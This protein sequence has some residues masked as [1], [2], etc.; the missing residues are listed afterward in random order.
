MGGIIKSAVKVASNT[1]EGIG[2]AAF[3]AVK[4]VAGGV[5]GVFT[6]DYSLMRD[7]LTDVAGGIGTTLTLGWTD[8]SD[9]KDKVEAFI[10]TLN[11]EEPEK[12]FHGRK[13]MVTSPDAPKRVIYGKTRVG[14]NLI[15]FETSG[16]DSAIAHM[17]VVLAPHRCDAVEEVWLGDQ[18]AWKLGEGAKGQFIGKLAVYVELGNQLGAN[19]V[20]VAN[21]PNWT[22]DHKVRG[23][24]Y[25]YL[26]LAYDKEVYGRGTPNVSAVVRGKSDILDPR[27][28][29]TG[30]T[31]NHALVVLDYLRYYY[32]FRV[33][34][35]EYNTDSFILGAAVCDEPVTVIGGGTEKRYTVNGTMSLAASPLDNLT[36][37]LKAGAAYC[38]Y[39]QGEFQY[40]S[41]KYIAPVLTLTEHDMIGGYQLISNSAG[42]AGTVNTVRASIVDPDA[43]YEVRQLKPMQIA[44]YISVDGEELSIDAKF[45][46][47]SSQSTAR[48]LSKLAIERSRYGLTI[49]A[50][51]TPKALKLSVGDRI[52]L[53]SDLYGWTK[54][55]RVE[56]VAFAVESG[57]S[58]S[59]REDAAAVW[60]WSVDDDEVLPVPP[61]ISLPS[62]LP[63]PVPTGFSV[64]EAINTPA[65]DKADKSTITFTSTLPT[66]DRV[67]SAKYQYRLVGESQWIDVRYDEAT[68]SHSLVVLSNGANYE[69]SAQSITFNGRVSEQRA[70]VT[71]QVHK[72]AI[73]RVDTTAQIKLPTPQR[74]ILQNRIDPRENRFHWKGGDAVF[75]WA[76]LSSTTPANISQSLAGRVDLHQIGYDV[77]V[78]NA[79]T[80]ELIF[81]KGD[82]KDNTFTFAYDLNKRL[83][84][85]G[86]PARNIRLVLSSVS[87]GGYQSESVEIICSNPAP[88]AVT[89]IRTES[90]PFS[91]SVEYARPED[92]D[93]IGVK[94]RLNAGGQVVKDYEL[95]DSNKIVFTGLQQNTEYTIDLV[96]VDEF[97]EGG[98][99]STVVSTV[100]L[101]ATDITGLGAW[102][103]QTDPVDLAFIQANMQND[104]IASEKI[105]SITAA[106]ITAG[107]ITAQVDVGT[108][109][110]IDGANGIVQTVTAA[111]E[112][113]VT[114]GAH[115]LNAKQYALSVAL[116]TTVLFGCTVDGNA[117]FAGE[118]EAATGTLNSVTANSDFTVD[119]FNGYGQKMRLGFDDGTSLGSSTGFQFFG[120]LSGNV[121]NTFRT[122]YRGPTTASA[123]DFV[124]IDFQLN[125]SNNSKTGVPLSMLMNTSSGDMTSSFRGDVILLNDGSGVVL[126]S[127]NGTKYK[128]TVDNS[129][130]LT[131][132]A[133]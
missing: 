80:G 131:T 101:G 14:G 28:G 105:S 88:S 93:W 117:A 89:G 7:G 124:G 47:T 31:D 82:I 132:V 12:E 58:L 129:G 72:V 43:D 76:E 66:D 110:L 56:A 114:M 121:Y 50:T 1:V 109:V 87:A 79:T 91:I 51:F 17:V 3:G 99:T 46:F 39:V 106:K 59:L 19:A 64:S 22:F 45:P 90:D 108:G 37:L 38:P 111:G 95:Y 78:Y 44:G 8:P 86:T 42:K 6:G 119:P 32:G 11:P 68:A 130:N 98:S 69:F 123:T 96:S 118:L 48:R 112:Y 2:Q 77:R 4:T 73:S 27:T 127:P 115:T 35:S 83:S 21:M 54:V 126:T 26:E 25:L 113:A 74:L 97:G 40:V 81:T 67:E 34:S 52:T 13:V 49:Q 5:T 100:D 133:Y 71:Y 63:I 61:A 62:R 30:Y 53:D 60:N 41:G 104:A 29:T 94:A 55:F 120:D 102:A 84:K 65:S 92:R 36:S 23:C 57:V 20:A 107:Q 18:L 103:T 24:T 9:N 75:T 85:S 10:D 16:D 125:T 116:G 15:A 33:D 128:L 122:Q 70:T